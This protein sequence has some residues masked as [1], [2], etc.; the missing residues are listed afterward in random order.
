MIANAYLT[1]DE[2]T[3][4]PGES[5]RRAGL[6]TESPGA[7]LRMGE[8][9]QIR[10]SATFHPWGIGESHTGSHTVCFCDVVS[11]FHL[12]CMVGWHAVF[13]VEE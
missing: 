6:H 11:Q 13:F 10:T 9:D 2:R 4:P 8:R 5:Q 1:V 12:I 7:T 3:V